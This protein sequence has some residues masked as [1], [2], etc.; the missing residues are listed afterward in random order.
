LNRILHGRFCNSNIHF[1]FGPDLPRELELERRGTGTGIACV[2]WCLLH[3]VAARCTDDSGRKPERPEYVSW[4]Q[5]S[6]K[7]VC[8]CIDGARDLA[9]SAEAA[10]SNGYA[11]E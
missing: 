2:A 10:K 3:I 9:G 8:E 5:T 11:G 7:V 1:I 6:D 4:A